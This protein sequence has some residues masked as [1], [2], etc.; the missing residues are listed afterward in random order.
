VGREHPNLLQD[1]PTPDGIDIKKLGKNGL[2][3]TDS[4]NAAQKARRL[5]KYEIGGDVHD[6]DCFHHLRNVWIKGM[7]KSV[8]ASL[9]SLLSD[10]LEKVPF[11]L[12][13]SCVYSAIARAWDKFFSLCANYPKGQGEHFAAWLKVNKPGTPLHHVVGA[14]GS[15]HDLCLMAAPAIYMN[16]HICFE[17]ADYLLRLPHKQDNIL[18]R[19]LFVL[20]TSEEIIAQSRLFAIFYIS[21][22][23]PMR[24]LA[25]KTPELHEWEWGPISNCGAIDTLRLKMMDLVEDPT[26]ILDEDFM[27]GM[28]SEYINILPPFKTYWE[29]LFEKK[30]MIVVASES[31]AK[32]LPYAEL[33][34]ELFH[35][36]DSTNAATNNRLVELAGVAAQAIL[37]ELHDEKKA[38]YKYLSISE[39]KYCVSGCPLE[40]QKALRGLEATNDRSESALGGTTRQLQLHGRI[41]IQN[42]AAVADAKSNGYFRRFTNKDKDRIHT[43][44][45][46][47][48]FCPE[49][50][51]CLLQ[52]AIQ[53][54]PTVVSTNREDLDN[55]REAKRKKE[56]MME[57]KGL[58]KAKESTIEASYYWEMY[59]SDACWK[60]VRTMKTML[61]RL[62]S[63]SAKLEALK[64][65]I[66][67]RVIGFGWTQFAITWSSKG[68]KR[69]VVELTHHMKMI[70][71]E[72]KKLTP[73]SDP[74]IQLPTRAELP[75]LGTATQQ[76]IDS[77]ETAQIDEE[78]FRKEVE[79]L[80]QQREDRGE[81]SIYSALQP[82]VCPEPD[83]L[84][85]K[86]IDV[87]YS[88]TLDSGEKV[89]RWCQGKVIA[90]VADTSK[91]TVCVR[92][93]AMPDVEGKEDVNEETQQVVPPRKFNKN[94]EGAWRLDI[95]VSVRNGN[96]ATS[97]KESDIE[98]NDG[99]DTS[100]SGSSGSEL[101][102]SDSDDNI[103]SDGE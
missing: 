11:E 36:S 13:V 8:S 64:E 102:E 92:W 18:L 79:E 21:F 4:C 9:R 77:N 91:P 45:M 66:R 67:M 71:K 55:Q 42:A 40:V 32:V 57:Q 95:N 24:W 80:R 84:V 78:Q 2:I 98:P 50:R 48:Q 38:T 87:L 43:K 75:V 88:F 25:A 22:C 99:S 5:L 54:A 97:N 27:M 69:S 46:F 10:S 17:Y 61:G 31:G 15:R 72:E 76:L 37:N 68:K 85:D 59:R 39:S 93:D 47:Y 29:H 65:N 1:I 26:N 16:R 53:V 7:E 74:A 62:N 56:E 100:N 30:R 19:C 96:D 35:P 6:L 44:G 81:G 28:F 41:S 103:Q 3:M 23:L 70:I 82:L 34:K 94:D 52:Y 83:E 20:M 73:P 60:N 14:Q 51:Q 49:I 33:R 101:N 90:L 63:E 89:L 12:R 58:M 86:R